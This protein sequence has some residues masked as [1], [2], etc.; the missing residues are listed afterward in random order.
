MPA[1]R[2]SE[3]SVQGCVSDSSRM[4]LCRPRSP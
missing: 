4:R 2:C 3:T 1:P